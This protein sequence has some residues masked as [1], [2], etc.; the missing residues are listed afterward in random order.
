MTTDRAAPVAGRW[1]L[2]TGLALASSYVGP[3]VQAADAQGAV[4]IDVNRFLVWRRGRY[5]VQQVDEKTTTRWQTLPRGG[6]LEEVVPLSAGGAA[7]LISYS[8]VQ[9]AGTRRDFELVW[10]DP[11]GA[12]AAVVPMPGYVFGVSARGQDL[13]VLTPGRL[14][15]W[16]STGGQVYLTAA[17]ERETQVHVDGA[18][19]WV[20]C[21][22]LD[23]RASV[24]DPTNRPAGCRTEHGVAF[25]GGT[26][27]NVR[28]QVCGKWLVEPLQKSMARS[29]FAV[30]ARSLDSG[31]VEGSASLAA[32]E[33]LCIDGNGLA[34]P[35]R[36]KQLLLPALTDSAPLA[37]VG[38]PVPSVRGEACLQ[39]DGRVT[40]PH[41]TPGRA[42]VSRP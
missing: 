33:L 22:P 3:W 12:V 19:G 27:T 34:A 6:L 32:S 30:R 9:A 28:P 23:Q 15:R 40:R 36:G 31:A 10:F 29:A 18:G 4:E 35:G 37:C 7:G 42:R 21:R 1:L 11:A 16:S 39:R 8:V 20:L 2:A 13:L 38:R 14:T 41:H 24:P 17:S 25:E 5:R 26:F